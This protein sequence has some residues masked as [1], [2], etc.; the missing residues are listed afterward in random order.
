MGR[1]D[2]RC[3]IGLIAAALLGGKRY[4]GGIGGLWHS[5]FAQLSPEGKVP[6]FL[7][8]ELEVTRSPDAGLMRQ[9]ATAPP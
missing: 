5:L 9:S 4:A 2:A 8:D 3:I 7:A 6:I 1:V